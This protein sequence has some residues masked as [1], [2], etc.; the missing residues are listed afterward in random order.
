MIPAWNVGVPKAIDGAIRSKAPLGSANQP[1]R[2]Q[3]GGF[4]R[5]PSPGP[6]WTMVEWA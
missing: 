1:A 3:P 5:C 2:L 4:G 6:V